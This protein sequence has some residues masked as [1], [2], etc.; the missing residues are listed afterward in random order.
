MSN[1]AQ[2]EDDKI[3]ILMKKINE[4][5]GKLTEERKKSFESEKELQN[6]SNITLPLLKKNLEE[7]KKNKL[8]LK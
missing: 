2:G 8:N 7:K 3:E 6:L 1:K 5:E 4:L